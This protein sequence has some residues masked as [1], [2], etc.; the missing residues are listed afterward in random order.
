MA[1]LCPNDYL[2]IIRSDVSGMVTDANAT[3][4]TQAERAAQDEIEGY[5]LHDYDVARTLDYSTRNLVTGDT[6]TPGDLVISTAGE[7][8]ICIA[9]GTGAEVA[10]TTKF[11]PD[12][13][14]LPLPWAA[15]T[16][17][18]PGVTISGPSRLQYLC[19]QERPSAGPD[20][21]DTDFF[22]LKRND[23][24]VMIFLDIAV[25]HFHA[26][27]N[28]NQVPTLRIERYEAAIDK[29]KRIRRKELT[30]AIPTIAATDDGSSGSALA[31]MVS[32]D[33]RNNAY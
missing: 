29:L 19:I 26:R 16:E 3:V 7:H 28:P 9:P 22:F 30:P 32:N 8:Y 12:R 13:Y 33:K 14:S 1:F 17:Y 25:Y 27:Q 5:L 18:A 24:L 2:F 20:L 15:S 6:Y 4:R 31:T 23:L 21:S 10:D 11:I